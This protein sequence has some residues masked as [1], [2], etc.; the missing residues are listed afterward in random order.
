MRGSLIK[1]KNILLLGVPRSGKSTFAKM[2]LKEYPN[3]NLIQEDVITSAY[4]QTTRKI[5]YQRK[6]NNKSESVNIEL[7]QEFI[8]KMIKQI[9]DY[10]VEFEPSL[11]FVLDAMSIELEEACKYDKNKFIVLFFG[12]PNISLENALDPSIIAASFLGPKTLK[13]FSSKASTTPPTNGSSIPIMV[14]SISFSIAKAVNLS[15]SIAPMLTHSAYSSIP[16]L[17]G[18]Q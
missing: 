12:Y 14:R 5:N 15:N 1:M 6:K 8:Y 16:A 11:N 18:A 10:S 13:P 9:F 2:I 3:F 7:D 4:I 17:P